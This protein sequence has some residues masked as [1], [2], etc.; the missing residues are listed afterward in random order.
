MFE[1]ATLRLA[2]HRHKMRRRIRNLVDSVSYS[3]YPISDAYDRAPLARSELKKV[4][5]A[6]P[7]HATARG[8]TAIF[9][10]YCGRT[11][12]FSFD[13]N[14]SARDYPHYFVSNNRRVLE[15]VTDF[16]WRPIFLDLP[17]VANPVEAA[18][19]AKIAK[20]LPHFFPDLRKY[21][22]LVYSDD[23]QRIYHAAIPGEIQLLTQS[24]AALALKLSPHVAENV[25]WEFTDS[26]MQARY[27]TQAHR[28]LHYLLAQLDAG[29]SL[30]TD[31]MFM[32]GY[33]LRDLH[34]PA[35]IA[36]SEQWYD[37]ILEC[38]IDCQ[39]AFDF[40]AQNESKIIALPAPKRKKY[41][42]QKILV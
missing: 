16:G 20:A 31:R 21:R 42:G 37:D 25:L 3:V 39:L 15:I 14:N 32:T 35:A 5:P 13:R 11:R 28:M 18:Q 8:D 27:R 9:S 2:R 33:G 22:F 34:D 41:L 36:L 30:A 10:T 38:G 24:G 17:I 26:L 4:I 19:Q 12:S 23:K 29:K 1:R 40:L 6:S 7:T